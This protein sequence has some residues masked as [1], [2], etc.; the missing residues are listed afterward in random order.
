MPE[1]SKKVNNPIGETGRR[2]ADVE[3]PL[4]SIV[5][6]AYNQS[7]YLRETIESVLAQDY[8]RIEHIVIDDGSTDDTPSVLSEYT[9]RVEWERHDN[10]GQTP[11]IN[12]GWRRSK[13]EIV[14][15]LNSDD[16]LLPGAVSKAVAYL[17]EHPESG[18]VFG[19][20]MFTTEDG[21]PIEKSKSPGSFFDYEK[22]VV[23]CEN[24]IAQPSAFIRRSVVE[25]VG[26]LDPFYYYFM[27]WDFWLKAGASH[28]VD[29][30]PELL[31]TYRL[32]SES[33]TV[34]QSAKA[35]PELERMYRAYFA[36]DSVPDAVRR[37]KSR[38]FAN[39]Y[40]TS[41][42]YYIK[43]DDKASAAKC[44]LKALRSYPALLFD[45]GMLHKFIY[46]LFGERRIYQGSREIYRRTRT[47]AAGR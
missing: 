29:Y 44:A 25:D 24:P 17:Q 2:D 41:G 36:L 22:F 40:F 20:S 33:K 5:T 46:C 18:I 47:I 11:T 7:A 42:G 32:H 37:H 31:S 14:T 1:D 26:D 19:D 21:T 13:G 23:E 35:A 30:I 39:M 34:A 15:W 10:M 4:V 6:P 43:G 16:T 3:R 9:G 8:P 38:A 12:K 27:D 28:P 45:A